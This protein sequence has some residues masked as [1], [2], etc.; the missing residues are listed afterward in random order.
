MQVTGYSCVG[1]PFSFTEITSYDDTIWGVEGH[2]YKKS[3]VN[4]V[5]DLKAGHKLLLKEVVQNNT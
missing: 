3:S 4:I 5:Y 1:L 2:P